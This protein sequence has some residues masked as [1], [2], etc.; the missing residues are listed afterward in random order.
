[1]QLY[2]ACFVYDIISF[3]L[4]IIL[5]NLKGTSTVII[6]THNFSDKLSRE[7]WLYTTYIYVKKL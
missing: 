4:V 7:W 2:E 3:T 5:N 6:G 1:M